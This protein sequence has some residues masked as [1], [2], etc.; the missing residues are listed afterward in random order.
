MFRIEKDGIGPYRHINIYPEQEL[1]VEKWMNKHHL[2]YQVLLPHHDAVIGRVYHLI[3]NVS[4]K[5]PKDILYCFNSELDLLNSFSK[6]ELLMLECL[7][8]SIVE[9]T[10]KMF[11]QV[12]VGES[13][14]VIFTT[15]ESYEAYLL[16]IEENAYS[17]MF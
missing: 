7:G 5:F 10:D 8:F 13:Q 15:K 12:L 2:I 11:Y 17:M 3:A 1:G 14:S 16:S 4:V 9:Y 6:D